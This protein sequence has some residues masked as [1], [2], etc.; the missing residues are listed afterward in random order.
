MLYGVSPSDVATL[1]TVAVLM[2]VVA[3]LASLLPAIR[4][5]RVDPMQMLR[6]E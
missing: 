1:S 4:A 5:A 3:A 2:L 6:E